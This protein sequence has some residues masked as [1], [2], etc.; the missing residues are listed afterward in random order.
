MPQ[1]VTYILSVLIV[2]SILGNLAQ[3]VIPA[4]AVN[5]VNDLTTASLCTVGDLRCIC[6]SQIGAGSQEAGVIG[7]AVVCFQNACGL[8]DAACKFHHSRTESELTSLFLHSNDLCYWRYMPASVGTDIEEH[9]RWLRGDSWRQQHSRYVVPQGT[10]I[11]LP[12]YFFSFSQKASAQDISPLVPGATTTGSNPSST[13][14]DSLSSSTSEGTTS[15]PTSSQ[16]PPLTSSAS[17]STD[18]SPATSFTTVDT[19]SGLTAGSI[20]AIVFGVLLALFLLAAA[21]CFWCC[22][23][24]F[25][26]RKKHGR[27]RRHRPTTFAERNGQ[28]RPTER[29]YDDREQLTVGEM[30]ENPLPPQPGEARVPGRTPEVPAEA[31]PGAPDPAVLPTSKRRPPDDGG[32]ALPGGPPRG[33]RPSGPP[34]AGPR[35]A[36]SR[37][38]RPD[39]EVVAPVV[40]AAAG[41]A[42]GRAAR[43]SRE[44]P[45]MTGARH[46]PQ[47][48]VAEDESVTTITLSSPGE[49]TPLRSSTESQIHTGNAPRTVPRT[50]HASARPVYE[51]PP[52]VPPVVVVQQPQDP[53]TFYRDRSR[54][55]ARS[56]RRRRPAV[57]ESSSSSSGEP[58]AKPKKSRNFGLLGAIGATAAGLAANQI[59]RA[60]S[61]MRDD[62]SRA[63]LESRRPRSRERRSE[64]QD[65]ARPPPRVDSVSSSHSSVMYEED[66]RGELIAVPHVPLGVESSHMEAESSISDDTLAPSDSGSQQGTSRRRPPPPPRPESRSRRRRVDE[67]GSESSEGT[68]TS[69]VLRKARLVHLEKARARRSD[70]EPIEEEGESEAAAGEGA[71]EPGA[72]ASDVVESSESGSDTE[73]E[74]L[75]AQGGSKRVRFT[76]KRRPGKG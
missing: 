63:D 43:R 48:D 9:T 55:R 12:E 53:E 17:R 49:G 40:G 19:G 44:G 6:T 74:D 56:R 4:C 35:H 14:S 27:R 61:R 28:I 13:T 69:S 57:E 3:F 60:R 68:V 75:E 59:R 58:E 73:V 76:N 62:D 72:L 41:Y 52:P 64:S 46:D 42:A 65:T 7:N 2:S 30:V 26:K 20:A 15:S 25:R 67:G 31:P 29:V 38:S 54:S 34:G 36:S 70:N 50:R 66:E 71:S 1:V 33:P 22:S 10:F 23:Y 47:F 18:S 39:G 5:C 45:V 51:Q 11:I 8:H 21:C 24:P 37:P 32:D 16:T